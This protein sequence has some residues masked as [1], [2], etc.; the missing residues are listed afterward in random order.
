MTTIVYHG[1][2]IDNSRAFRTSRGRAVHIELIMVSFQWETSETPLGRVSDVR[3]LTWVGLNDR[4]HLRVPAMYLPSRAAD[5]K[6][7]GNWAC[8]FGFLQPERH[9]VDGDSAQKPE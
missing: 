8:V 4:V 3:S 1:C 9:P 6:S 7:G 5:L 2:L